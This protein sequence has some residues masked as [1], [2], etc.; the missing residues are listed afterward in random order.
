MAISITLTAVVSLLSILL[1]P[2]IVITSA[3]LLDVTIST[4]NSM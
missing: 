4:D 1:V 3:T 2:F